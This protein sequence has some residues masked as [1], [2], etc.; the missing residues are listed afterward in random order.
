MK[1][2]P[3]V[4]IYNPNSTGSSKD[5]ALEFAEKLKKADASL[6]VTCTE[7]EY[8]GHGEVLAKEYASESKPYLLISSSGDGGYHELINGALSVPGS[9][10]I[11]GLLPGGNANDHYNSLHTDDVI[12][13]ILRTQVTTIDTIKVEAWIKDELWV[14]YAHSYAGIGLTSHIGETLTKTKLN[15]FREVWIVVTHLFSHSPVKIR[16]HGRTYHYNS[17]IFSNIARMSKVLSLTDN[18]SFTDGKIEITESQSR[19]AFSLLAHFLTGAIGGFK[20]EQR[21]KSY[22]FTCARKTSMQLDGEVYYFPARTKVKVQA[23]QG[24]LNCII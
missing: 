4:I 19:H 15:P 14:R 7:T 1:T 16:R 2:P 3:I 22:V 23:V 9:K 5:Q 13:R 6:D 11:T 12:E 17:I 21:V 24:N 18:A 10:V 20:S 8:A